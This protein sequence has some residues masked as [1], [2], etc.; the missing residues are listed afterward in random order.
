MV[1]G[2]M[3]RRRQHQEKH[4]TMQVQQEHAQRCQ[5]TLYSPTF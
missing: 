3:Q 2:E 1:K 5:Q 4:L